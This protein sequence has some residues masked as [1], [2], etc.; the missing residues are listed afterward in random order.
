M[1]GT[2]GGAASPGALRAV[3]DHE[4]GAY[5]WYV[6]AVLC[7]AHTIAIIDRFVMVLVTEPLR[8]AM[9]LSDTQ[10]GLL[11]GTGFAILYCGFAVPLGA[12]ADATNR[13]NL[14]MVGLTLW[15]LATV[16]AA[17]ATSFEMLFATRILVGMGEAC[18]VPAGMS[19]L[20]AYFAPANLARGTAI[21]GLGANFG[22]GFA[23]LG[24]G[25][26]LTALTATGGIALPGG[27]HLEPWQGIFMA[28][29]LTAAP[30][31][32]L[33]LWLREPSRAQHGGQGVNAHIASLR[34]GLSYIATNL[35]SYA[36]F[37]LIGSMTAVTGYAV[38]SWSSSLFVRMHGLTPA[39]AGK[40]IG[41]IGIFAGP[42]GTI[43]GGIVLD[44]LRARDI[45]G[46]PLVVMGIGSIFA[47]LFAG[48]AAF[49]PNL[50]LASGLFCLFVFESTF[51]LP[52]LYV[53][54]QM[55]TPDRFRGIAASF[56]MMVYTLAGLGLG[57]AAVGA[58]SDRLDMGDSSLGLGI[59]IVEFAMV[60]AIVPT[61]LVARQGF[62]QQMRAVAA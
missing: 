2:I 43:S 41:L 57:P 38:T 32:I 17:F 56:N 27:A 8:V 1:A 48:S 24:G 23:F 5:K 52:A 19:L 10:L 42:L 44:R 62:Q 13:R 7:A 12:V 11:Q 16:T 29:G 26:L 46:A 49:A 58:I 18:L 22:Y 54:M 53:G 34:N 35:R 59:V 9:H 33:L 37:L 20:A 45:A 28:A 36:P 39:D 55:L 30:V 6:A 61:A 47:L 14:I 51:V 21:F 3:A 40:L 50:T 60:L 25:A 15:S 31:L 4:T